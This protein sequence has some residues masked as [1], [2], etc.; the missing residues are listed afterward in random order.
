MNEDKLKMLLRETVFRCQLAFPES[1]Q[2]LKWFDEGTVIQNSGDF[3]ERI[4]KELG[5][6]ELEGDEKEPRL[7]FDF[8]N[9]GIIKFK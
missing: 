4:D 1:E 6:G 7:D 5:L 3:F 8:D 2:D 9:N